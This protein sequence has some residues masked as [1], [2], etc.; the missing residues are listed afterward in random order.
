MNQQMHL[1]EYKSYNNHKY[2]LLHDLAPECHLQGVSE[3]KESEVQHCTL[4]KIALT[5][6]LKLLKCLT[7]RVHCCDINLI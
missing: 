1:I 5:I 2:Q 6:I 4:G 3:H 7:S